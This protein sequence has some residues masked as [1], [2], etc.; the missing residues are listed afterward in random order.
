MLSGRYAFIDLRAFL[1]EPMHRIFFFAVLL[2]LCSPAFSQQ[3]S[4]VEL[5]KEVKSVVSKFPVPNIPNLLFYL[6][7]NKNS[8]TIIYEAN[9]L[10]DGKLDPKNPVS[11]YWLRYQEDSSRRELNWIQ[12]WLAYGIDF[13]PAK[14]GSGNYILSPVALKHRKITL[15]LDEKGRPVA[16]M[17][18]AG[19]MA[20]LK[21]IYAMAEETS[22]LPTVK[23][24][25]LKGED[26][27]SKEE[28]YE[29]IFPKQ[30]KVAQ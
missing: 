10:A 4:V 20:R 11:V 23:Y 28:V 5:N 18:L 14:D 16:T 17:K 2:F 30:N 24:V 13:E 7:R 6:Q 27:H 15:S 19:K 25:Q 9:L 22:W 3:K 21:R 8:N 29:Y 12:R 1:F 26:I